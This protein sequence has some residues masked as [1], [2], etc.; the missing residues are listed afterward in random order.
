MNEKNKIKSSSRKSPQANLK[1][2]GQINKFDKV[3]ALET[4]QRHDL[5]GTNKANCPLVK[6]TER[7]SNQSGI[8]NCLKTNQVRIK[9]VLII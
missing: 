6:T 3:L 2:N 4:T 8:F 1:L 7:Q 9:I 5:L